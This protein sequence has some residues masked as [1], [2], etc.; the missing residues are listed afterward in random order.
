[1]PVIQRQ[2]GNKM[3]SIFWILAFGPFLSAA[4]LETYAWT[5]VK[6]SN[7]NSIVKVTG[8]V[9]PQ[10]GALNIESARVQGRILGILA[11]EGDRVKPGDPLLLVNSAECQ[12]LTEEKRVAEKRQIPDL[13]E[14]VNN[15]EK[16]LG[17]RIRDN[18]CEIVS[19]FAG[20]VTKRGVESGATF[21]VGDAL[22]T[23]LD[24]KRMSVELDLA[25]RDLGAVRTG[26]RVQFHL[27]S[28]P[29]KAYA[30]V[31]KAVVP[32]IDAASR[33]VRVRLQPVTL[34]NHANLDGMIFGEIETGS[35]DPVFAIP[36]QALVFSQNT[37][38]VVKGP[39]SKPVVVEVDV[40]GEAN[41]T[42]SVR[43]KQKG[44][45]KDGDLVATNNAIFLFRKVNESSGPSEAKAQP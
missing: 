44:G 31:V 33:T 11:R 42:A 9:T 35:G 23:V 4:A 15:R 16:Q 21:N 28:E 37:R 41:N 12:S 32:A 26:Q 20:S 34:S 29:N 27:A 6:L 40:L 19:S 45:L 36:S 24:T 14:G 7:F 5:G 43:P 30:S 25:E 18:R 17:L 2:G 10:E 38:F 13:L 3:S 1:M 22:M 8:R 39:E